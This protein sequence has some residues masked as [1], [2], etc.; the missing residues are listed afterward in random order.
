MSKFDDFE[1]LVLGGLKDI[2]SKDLK[3]LL[4]QAKDDAQDFLDSSAKK[5]QK[6]TKQLAK[7]DLSKDEFEDLVRGQADLAKLLALTKEGVGKA[8]LQ[9]FRNAL[10]DLVVDSAFKVF[11]P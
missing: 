1:K 8:A 2:L 9:R 4:Q 5:L 7:G 10:V 3:P 11:L 6:W